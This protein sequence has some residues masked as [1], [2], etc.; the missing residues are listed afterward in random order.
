MGLKK[1]KEVVAAI[2]TCRKEAVSHGKSF[3]VNVLQYFL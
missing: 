2:R 1:V 3:K